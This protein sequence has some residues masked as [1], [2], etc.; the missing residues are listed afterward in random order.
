MH[1]DSQ[2]NVSLKTI[3]TSE[4]PIPA[5]DSAYSPAGTVSSHELDLARSKLPFKDR[6]RPGMVVS[7]H[8]PQERTIALDL[9]D[10]IKL[11]VLLCPA[12]ATA[13]AIKIERINRRENGLA[14]G[15]RY[16]CALMVPGQTNEAFELSL[17]QQIVID[18][19]SMD[20]EV[21]MEYDSATRYY[22]VLV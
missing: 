1:I 5:G 21:Q 10:D 14:D 13:D 3:C 22:Y 9:L 19:N 18:V 6:L 12:E 17:W 8:I 4:Q 7:Y 11:A 20:T 15:G 16:L 2:H